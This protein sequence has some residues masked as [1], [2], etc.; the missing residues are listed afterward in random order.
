MIEN[1]VGGLSGYLQGSFLLAYLAVYLGGLLVSFT[2]CVYPVVPITVA[3]IG[4]HG[5]GARSRGFVLSM[6]YVLGMAVTYILLGAAARR[7]LE[8][9]SARSRAAPGPIF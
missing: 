2:P 9:S 7:S 1:F 4:A 3:C 5:G 8:N 6:F